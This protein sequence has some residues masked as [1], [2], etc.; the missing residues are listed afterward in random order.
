M[1]RVILIGLVSV[2]CFHAKA[3]ETFTGTVI[4][5]P[6]E[7]I[8]NPQIIQNEY[9]LKMFRCNTTL[10][11]YYF[12]S[13]LIGTFIKTGGMSVIGCHVKGQRQ[14]NQIRILLN[15]SLD[16]H[17]NNNLTEPVWFSIPKIKDADRVTVDIEYEYLDIC[18]DCEALELPPYIGENTHVV[19][20]NKKDYTN[21]FEYDENLPKIDF[22]KYTL[23]GYT[24]RSGGP[25]SNNKYRY[26]FEIY[27]QEKFTNINIIIV[28]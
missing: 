13:T 26:Y 14:G 24:F 21:L 5:L 2:L 15:V 16:G 22:N 27:P 28:I 23:I 3:Q 1:N 19:I 9:Q 12:N 25:I 17:N 8:Q 10:P 4:E 20:E 7:I 18:N 6:C 11:Q